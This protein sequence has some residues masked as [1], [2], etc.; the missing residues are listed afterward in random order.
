MKLGLREEVLWASAGAGRAVLVD[1]WA[2]GLLLLGLSHR[3]FGHLLGR[4]VPPG[5]PGKRPRHGLVHQ[6]VQAWAR[7]RP[8]RAM[9][10][11]G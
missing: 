3:A 5:V 2:V 8:G 7:T 11:P 4:A 6:A 10:G 9:L 1:C